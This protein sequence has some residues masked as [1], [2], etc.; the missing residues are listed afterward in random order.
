[1]LNC[2]VVDDEPLGREILA[3]Y[4]HQQPELKLVAMCNNSSQAAEILNIE[5]IDL[6][7][8]D[9][10]MPGTNGVDFLKSIASPPK[11]IFTTAYSEYAVM[12]FE[13]GVI[14][15]LL[16]PVTLERFQ[17]SMDRLFQQNTNLSDSSLKAHTYFKVSGR[18]VKITH[19]QLIS[20]RSVKDYMLIRTPTG[21]M[22]T[23][24][25]MKNLEQ[26]LPQNQFIRVQRSYLVNISYIDVIDK[27]FLKI[28]GEE[29]PI[30]EQYRKNL[31][32]LLTG[33]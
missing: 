12:G 14:D 3:D 2:I 31:A 26:L 32:D 19:D 20:A 22:I 29:I 25:T 4:I 6:M 30:G 15:Y 27:H 8:L 16:K 33:L 28:A 1:M 21:N 17:L 9:I 23:H 24:M 7:F 11:T 13:L 18:L 10:N 5:K